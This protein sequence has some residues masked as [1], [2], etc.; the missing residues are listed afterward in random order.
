[1][2]NYFTM[3]RFMV[4]LT[5]FVFG[6]FGVKA[7]DT[8]TDII[9]VGSTVKK[10][11]SNQYTYSKGPVWFNDSV[12]LFVDDALSGPDI[13]QFDPISKQISKWPTNSPHCS[14]LTLD[15]NENLIGASYNVIMINK[16]GQVIK[17]LASS[18]N[19]K[20]FD[21][22][23][24]LIADKNGGVYFCDPVFTPGIF[25]QDKTAVYYIDSIGNVKRVIDD[26]A[27]PNGPALSPDGTKLYVVDGSNKYVYSWD[28]APDGSL[29][30][31]LSFAEL[32]TKTTGGVTAQPVGETIDSFGN[33]Y[34]STEIGIQVFSPQGVAITTIEVPE[35]PFDC[36]FGGK[37]FKTLYITALKNLYSIDL[38]YPGYAV[39][40]KN[41]TDAKTISNQPS[42]NVYPN[43][44]SD[45]L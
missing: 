12:L 15:R 31:K 45:Y 29:S 26:L 34:V 23:I 2:K 11:S 8:H 16:A 17:T 22:P 4:V 28:V 6:Q 33:I 43:P 39:S 38:N 20:P 5:I 32:K 7:Q 37:D 40:R 24:D 36:D 44:V 27:E 35:S 25:P 10:L 21:N 9:P 18:Y 3:I 30:G 13:Y 42:V 14:G 41:M 1:M 19:D